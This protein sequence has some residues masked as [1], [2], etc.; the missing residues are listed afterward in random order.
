MTRTELNAVERARI[1]EGRL[2]VLGLAIAEVRDVGE[3]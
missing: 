2:I 1:V 3:H